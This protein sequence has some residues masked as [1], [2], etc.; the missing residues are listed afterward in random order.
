MGKWTKEYKRLNRSAKV[1]AAVRRKA[2]VTQATATAINR[3]E[4]GT[5]NYTL[6]EG[7]RPGGRFYVDVESD[8]PAE[9]FGSADTKR[10]NALRRARRA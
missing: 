10:I 5:A 7:I 2:R 4:K 3:S 8:N 6:R 1:Q 9:E